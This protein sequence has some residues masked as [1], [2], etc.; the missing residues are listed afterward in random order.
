MLR[1]VTASF[2]LC[3]MMV[4]TATSQTG[5]AYCLCLKTIFVG[6]CHCEQVAPLNAPV[7]APEEPCCC[8][9]ESEQSPCEDEPA[10]VTA[11]D[12]CMINLNLQLGEFTTPVEAKIS[13]KQSTATPSF[14][15]PP[16]VIEIPTTIQLRSSHRPRGPPPD[17]VVSQVPLFLWHS[18][19]LV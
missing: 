6:D 4:A 19:F 8:C 9:E 17:P 5:L 13:E 7:E 1:K 12:D 16:S 11:C 14:E 2:L 18:V 15:F 10:E 3:L